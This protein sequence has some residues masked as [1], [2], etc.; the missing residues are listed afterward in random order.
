M[1]HGQG[2][3]CRS[4]PLSLLYTLVSYRFPG[5]SPSP[6][7]SASTSPAGTSVTISTPTAANFP[8][9]FPAQISELK[10]NLEHGAMMTSKELQPKHLSVVCSVLVCLE[11][12]DICTHTC[13]ISSLIY[14]RFCHLSPE[15]FLLQARN[16]VS[17]LPPN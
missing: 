3:L 1:L 10:T 11:E 7:D 9:S 5:F 13:K 2:D 4:V 8:F 12:T 14:V 15:K 6:E 17:Q 16:A